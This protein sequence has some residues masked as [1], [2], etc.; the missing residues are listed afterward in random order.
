M[1]DTQKELYK[2]L[3]KIIDF[4]SNNVFQAV[5]I[6]AT[7]TPFT[8]YFLSFINFLNFSTLYILLVNTIPLQTF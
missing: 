4:S 6:F 1:D 2:Q 3:G 5:V 8:F 7:S